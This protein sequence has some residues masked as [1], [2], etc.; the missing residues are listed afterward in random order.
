MPSGGAGPTLIRML[1]RR[2]ALLAL[3]FL[4][5]C[6]ADGPP[7]PQDVAGCWLLQWQGKD[8]SY[9]PAPDSVRLDTARAGMPDHPHRRRV[10]FGG[11]RNDFASRR[12][13]DP[14]PWHRDY[15][16]SSWWME[17]ADSVHIDFSDGYTGWRVELRVRGKRMVGMATFDAYWGPVPR[18]TAGVRARRYPCPRS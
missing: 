2:L 8:S 3:L 5:G 12:V 11:W 4:A 16:E 9:V 17:T 15:S 13:G 18:P 6:R 10:A 1:P 7:A 14:L